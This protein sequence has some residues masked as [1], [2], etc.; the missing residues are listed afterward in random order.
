[1]NNILETQV[2]FIENKIKSLE[3]Q[4]AYQNKSQSPIFGKNTPMYN[5]LR[6]TALKNQIKNIKNQITFIENCQN[7][8]I[9][10]KF[11]ENTPM[12]NSLCKYSF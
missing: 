6:K 3:N 8:F 7:K 11:G 2:T 5:P 9:S 4:I 10:P 12:Y 1:M